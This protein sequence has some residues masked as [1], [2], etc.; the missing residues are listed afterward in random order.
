M[1]FQV[2]RAATHAVGS[3]SA[4]SKK[5]EQEKLSEDTIERIWFIVI[6]LNDCHCGAYEIEK[7]SGLQKLT[8]IRQ[9][10][11]WTS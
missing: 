4:V 6:S 1:I 10:A 3:D 11:R 2:V 7:T 5:R 8:L 9:R